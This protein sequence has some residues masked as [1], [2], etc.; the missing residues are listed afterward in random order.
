VQ[1]IGTIRSVS[2]SPV[3]LCA[4]PFLSERVLTDEEPLR[5]QKRFQDNEFLDFVVAAAKAAGEKISNRLGAALIWQEPE[6][7]GVT[8]F[9]KAKYG[10]NPVRFTMRGGSPAMDRKHGNEEYG[11]IMLGA[12][13]R[14][15][16]RMSNGRVLPPQRKSRA[17]E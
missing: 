17:A 12:I 13:L 10:L 11:A 14:K 7:G 8:G 1:L 16:D 15:L 4:A 3:L 2:D 6:T 9:T 5:D